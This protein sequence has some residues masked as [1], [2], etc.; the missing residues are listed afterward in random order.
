LTGS[1]RRKLLLGVTSF[2]GSGSRNTDRPIDTDRNVVAAVQAPPLLTNALKRPSV[3]ILEQ[4]P[5]KSGESRT[6]IT[7]L[8]DK[9]EGSLS[10][11]NILS[12]KDDDGL[13]SAA[14]KLAHQDGRS[15]VS[16]ATGVSAL[17]GFQ[18]AVRA[19]L[20]REDGL[21]RWL[22]LS[23]IAVCLLTIA[24]GVVTTTIAAKSIADNLA[25]SNTFGQDMERGMLNLVSDTLSHVNVGFTRTMG[26]RSS[27]SDALV[28]VVYQ[29]SAIWTQTVVNVAAG[30]SM[31]MDFTRAL[32]ELQDRSDG[33]HAINN[34]VT[35]S[36]PNAGSSG[37]G[38]LLFLSRFAFFPSF[39]HA[40]CA[41]VAYSAAWGRTTAYKLSVHYWRHYRYTVRILPQSRRP[42]LHSRSVGVHLPKPPVSLCAHFTRSVLM[43]CH[44]DQH[45]AFGRSQH[46][47][48]SA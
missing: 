10:E 28:C 21:V 26:F 37:V 46:P 6:S 32:A 45:L 14:N 34:E 22:K 43:F 4:P 44:S 41:L 40:L 7:M 24:S 13:F 11:A 39:S 16:G 36:R 38:P 42:V 47:E 8:A 31:Q 27:C 5:I 35:V 29:E 20:S 19:S 12:G 15:Q 25:Y 23:L 30:F 17:T 9:P 18:N 3:R 33:F 1:S 48:H 2:G